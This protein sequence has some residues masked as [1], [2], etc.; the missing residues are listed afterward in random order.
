[1]RVAA[2]CSIPSGNQS[3]LNHHLTRA[4]CTAPDHPECDPD[5]EQDGAREREARATSCA[6]T[7]SRPSDPFGPLLLWGRMVFARRS[8][9][10]VSYCS[11]YD[12]LHLFKIDR[13]KYLLSQAKPPHRRH[14]SWRRAIWRGSRDG[15]RAIAAISASLN[16]TFSLSATDGKAHQAVSV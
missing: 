14:P 1:M 8:S 3:G 6:T 4:E 13:D 2:R 7:Q 15:S 10:Y 5:S 11:T 12:L 16:A 9:L